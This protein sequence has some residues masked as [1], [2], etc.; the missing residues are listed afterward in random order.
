MPTETYPSTVTATPEQ[1]EH[2]V[3]EL[4]PVQGQIHP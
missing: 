4:L 1:V 3:L 2:L